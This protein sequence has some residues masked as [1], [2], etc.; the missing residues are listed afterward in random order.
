MIALTETTH[1]HIKSTW[2]QALKGYKL[3]H[4]PSLY[5]KHTKR[6]SGGA[7][8]AIDTNTYTN[9]EPY[10]APPHLQHH[11]AMA[12]LTPKA[13][14]KLIAISIYMPHHNTNQGNKTYKEA[15]QWLT[16]TLTEDL[17]HAAMILGGSP[18]Y[19]LG[20]APLLPPSTRPLLH[21]HQPQILRRPLHTYLY[22]HKLA[23]RPLAFP[24]PHNRSRL[25]L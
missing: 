12:L 4:N 14:S 11:I 1:R 10:Q 8:L 5:N 20:R 2:R 17:P 19:T 23:T 21:L 9:S 7:I 16:K 25:C 18:S 13:G 22:T 15:L 3:V 24:P 6:C